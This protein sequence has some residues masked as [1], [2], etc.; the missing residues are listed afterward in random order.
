MQLTLAQKEIEK[1]IVDFVAAKGVSLGNTNVHV[2]LIT[3]AGNVRAIIDISTGFEDVDQAVAPTQATEVIVPVVTAEPPVQQQQAVTPVETDEL[4][5]ERIKAEL[6]KRGIEYLPKAHTPTLQTMLEDVLSKESAQAA[7]AAAPVAASQTTSNLFGAPVKADDPPFDI[8]PP[9]QA[10]P[11]HESPF[12]QPAKS[13]EPEPVQKE[14]KVA[15][16]EKP[17]FGS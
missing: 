4:D 17:L 5:R 10:A 15:D 13:S 7:Q 11:V 16:E 3:A 12:G 14:D 1:A 2:T 8:D 6:D 9:V